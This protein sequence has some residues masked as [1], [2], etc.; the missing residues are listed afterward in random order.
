MENVILAALK[1]YY[2]V[3]R[4]EIIKANGTLSSLFEENVTERKVFEIPYDL[5]VDLPAFGGGNWEG[6][7]VE[8]S[9]AL[10]SSHTDHESKNWEDDD[11]YRKADHWA[12]DDKADSDGMDEHVL[13]VAIRRLETFPFLINFFVKLNTPELNDD[14]ANIHCKLEENQADTLCYELI[15]RRPQI[16]GH[17]SKHSKASYNKGKLRQCLTNP[18][19]LI[20][21]VQSL[22]FP[23]PNVKIQAH[24]KHDSDEF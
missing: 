10:H 6:V 16:D 12:K 3:S 4:F 18:Y 13:G 5:S 23:E 8:L 19:L 17:S 22:N 15:G 20:P 7:P 21:R 2:I 1:L 11:E 24:K 9:I 14:K